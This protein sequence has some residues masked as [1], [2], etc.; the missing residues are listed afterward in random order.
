[1]DEFRIVTKH[2]RTYIPEFRNPGDILVTPEFSPK[3]LTEKV[4]SRNL[5]DWPNPNDENDEIDVITLNIPET[6]VGVIEK[7]KSI[8]E[9]NFFEVKIRKLF[10][11]GRLSDFTEG[12]LNEMLKNQW[13]AKQNNSNAADLFELW[14]RET[15]P[16][17]SL[18]VQ[19]NAVIKVTEPNNTKS[20]LRFAEPV[21]EFKKF[22]TVV[23]AQLD[24]DLG[25]SANMFHND[26]QIDTDKDVVNLFAS[27]N[28][29]GSINI[30]EL[31]PDENLDK[32]A[33]TV[34]VRLNS[35]NSETPQEPIYPTPPDDQV[36]SD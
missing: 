3:R 9:W 1:M 26:Q 12:R 5:V 27:P 28:G 11:G 6:R 24:F 32:N 25:K 20:I 18:Q 13:D 2:I 30:D 16:I 14:V 15:Q 34:Q 35:E 17:V 21:Q 19:S 29:G 23:S 22:Q 7:I 31:L 33:I 10:V 36:E 8:Y 4:R